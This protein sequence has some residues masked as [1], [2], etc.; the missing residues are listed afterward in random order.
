MTDADVARH[1]GRRHRGRRVAL[2][3][4][5]LGVALLV[6]ALIA[7]AVLLAAVP[8]VGDARARAAVILRE[9]G[10]GASGSRC[11]AGWRNQS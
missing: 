5:L 4:L 7:G 11:R 9:H 8:G 10:A 1:P 6:M 3:V 2:A